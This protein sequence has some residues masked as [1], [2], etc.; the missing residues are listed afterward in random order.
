MG[1][2]QFLVLSNLP[3]AQP[4]HLEAIPPNWEF[5]EADTCRRRGGQSLRLFALPPT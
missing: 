4:A 5:R 2:F 1:F 3:M